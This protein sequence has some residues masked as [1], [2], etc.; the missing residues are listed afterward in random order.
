MNR[1]TN[2]WPYNAI[3]IDNSIES[4]VENARVAR[5]EASSEN[6]EN[7]FKDEFSFGPLGKDFCL[8]YKI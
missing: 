4:L 3:S 1:R 6:A 5:D 7:L 8:R 2:G